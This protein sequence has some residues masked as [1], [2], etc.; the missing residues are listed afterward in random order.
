MISELFLSLKMQ[1]KSHSHCHARHKNYVF[2][3]EIISE[4]VF[5]GD[6]C[7]PPQ[8]KGGG[9]ETKLHISLPT[10]K[11][12]FHA[13][14]EKHS[15]KSVLQ[16]FFFFLYAVPG[17]FFFFFFLFGCL[18]VLF[19][20]SLL[21]KGQVTAGHLRDVSSFV[22]TCIFG[23]GYLP[24]FFPEKEAVWWPQVFEGLSVIDSLV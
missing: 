9:S 11:M 17:F 8:K 3:S 24:D 6:L 16:R 19:C 13:S 20:F 7:L 5:L 18:F 2:D 15:Q 22:W 12:S 21:L 4:P 10:L 14:K 23:V 1:L